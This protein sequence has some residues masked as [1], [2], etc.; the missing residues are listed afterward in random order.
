[1]LTYIWDKECS[2][3]RSREKWHTFSMQYSLSSVIIVEIIK[4]E[5][6]YGHILELAYWDIN[7]GLLNTIETEINIKTRYNLYSSNCRAEQS[8]NLLLV[9]P[10]HSFMISGFIETYDHMF[11]R[12]KIKTTKRKWEIFAGLRQRSHSWFLTP[13]SLITIFLFITRPRL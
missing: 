1:M 12:S 9:S 2:N 5:W 8:S 6:G 3:K 4:I 13:K 7:Q 11:V 10:A